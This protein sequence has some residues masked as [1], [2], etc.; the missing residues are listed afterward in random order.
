MLEKRTVFSKIDIRKTYN[1]TLLTEV[2]K[3]S[4][5]PFGLFEFPR[6]PCN[7]GNAEQTFKRLMDSVFRD[8]DFIFVYVDDYLIAPQN[9]EDHFKHLE[10]I[11]SR[12]EKNGVTVNLDKSVFLKRQIFFRD[13]HIT[14]HGV[15]NEAQ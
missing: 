10:T 11:F 8:L 9:E 5:T 6:M 7:L 4:N 13:Y 1:C 3:T 15:P 14:S 12:L 2:E